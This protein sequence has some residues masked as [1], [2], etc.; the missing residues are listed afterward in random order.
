[1]EFLTSYAIGVALPDI[2]GD[3]SASLDQ[4]SWILTTYSTCFLIGV[5]LSN[6]LA[7]RIGYRRHMTTAVLLYMFAAIGCALSHTL[8]DM[9]VFRAAM[10]YAGG[11]FLVRGQT[12]INLAFAGVSR[13]KALFGFAI[14][15]VGVARLCG[16]AAGGY[17]TEWHSWRVIF[18]LNVPMS[19]G[20]LALLAAALPDVKERLPERARRLDIVGLVLLAAWVTSL[21]IALSRG[22]RD[23][24]LA[25]PF[26]L[27]LTAA[28]VLCLPLF[29]WW[30]LRPSNTAPIISLRTYRNRN[31]GI[32]SIYVVILGMMLYGQL[33]VVPQFLRNV[34][35]H[36][37][38]GAGQL[39][40]FN[41]AAFA[42]GL[43]IGALL[44][45]P[46][47]FR[48]ALAVGAATFTA[49][50]WTWATRLTPD[51]S[52]R[53]MLLPL[54][55]TG[56][57]AGWQIGPLSTLI[58]S[59][60]PDPLMGEAMELYLCQ[61]QLGG[62]WGIAILA[63]L[64]DRRESF[65]SSRLGEHVSDYDIAGGAAS[66]AEGGNPLQQGAVALHAA[67]LPQADAQAGA[68]ALLHGRLVTQAIVNAFADTFLYQAALGVVALLLIVCLGRGRQVKG[69]WR[70]VVEMVR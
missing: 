35:Q 68:M 61:R 18:F 27:F 31:F 37:A 49:G 28:F 38:W 46:L 10:G 26:I 30:E 25:D 12:A 45:K 16:A 20:A 34:Q 44:M 50:M 8:A 19:L 9:I 4:G 21:Q 55:L 7:S 52:D 2:Q 41:A 53:A 5:V 3:L 63:I 33:Y 17:L 6:W 62:S 32:G 13:F 48:A 23:D 43:I 54:A 15:V 69:A 65:W 1:M 14:G 70:W 47:G 64:V 22:E 36:S 24:W 58:N 59:G 60:T 40:S 11:T 56:M 67:G 51:I 42:V 57:G 66:V 39:Q 29:I